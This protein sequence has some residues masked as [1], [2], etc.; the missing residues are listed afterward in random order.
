MALYTRRGDDGETELA[1]GQR[2]PKD[3]LRIEVYGTLD[4]LIATLGLARALSCAAVNKKEHLAVRLLDIQRQL[5]VLCGWLATPGA[6]FPQTWAI[7]ETIHELEQEIDAASALTS[8]LRDFII[9]GISVL[10]AV[11]HQSRTVC[12]HAERRA[13]SLFRHTNH[14]AAPLALAYLNRLSDWLFAQARV[15]GEPPRPLPEKA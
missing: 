11:L 6:P 1:N 12:R 14:D 3:A 4:E 10:E 2:V 8:P 13:V 9:P 5:S 7:A 15:A